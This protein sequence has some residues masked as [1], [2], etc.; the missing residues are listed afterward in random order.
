M[1]RFYFD[2]GVRPV[3]NP[4]LWGNEVW[5][6]GTKQVPFDADAPKDAHLM[7]LCDNPHLPESDTPGVIVR[8]VFNTSMCSKYA[9][10]RV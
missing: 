1:N 7:S 5:R 2:T 3:N 9:Y 8:E 10:F 6:N 4:N